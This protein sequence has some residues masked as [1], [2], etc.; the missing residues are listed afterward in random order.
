MLHLNSTF[1][2]RGDIARSFKIGEISNRSS[3]NSNKQQQQ[4]ENKKGMHCQFACLQPHLGRALRFIRKTQQL[5]LIFKK[6]TSWGV[7]FLPSTLFR[8][9]RR[10]NSRTASACASIDSSRSRRLLSERRS[11]VKCFC[12]KR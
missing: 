11:S 3:S 6:A 7:D 4:H 5:G 8:S 2:H 12:A 1:G 10:P 9:G